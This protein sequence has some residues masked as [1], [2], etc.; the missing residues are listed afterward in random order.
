MPYDNT[1]NVEDLAAD[2]VALLHEEASNSPDFRIM[3]TIRAK[4]LPTKRDAKLAEA[5]RLLIRKSVKRKDDTL[6]PSFENRGMGGGLALIGRTGGGKSRSL[7]RYFD[8]HRVCA[9]TPTAR[10]DPP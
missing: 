6:P 10:P 8:K 7:Q 4:F 9:D 5:L 2:P 1:T 3:E